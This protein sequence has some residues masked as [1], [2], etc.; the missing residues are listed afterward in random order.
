MK[1]TA[2]Y[3]SPT[4]NTKKSVEAMAAALDENFS[5]LD[6]TLYENSNETRSFGPDETV[7][8]GLCRENTDGGSTENGRA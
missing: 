5:T 6:L 4:G 1:T 8:A 3:F 2:V 7:N